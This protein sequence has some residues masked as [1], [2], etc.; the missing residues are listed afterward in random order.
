MSEVD[1]IIA[2]QPNSAYTQEHALN[3]LAHIKYAISLFLNSRMV[4]AEELCVKCDPRR[5]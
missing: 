3:D 4:E 1:D 2:A 5:Y